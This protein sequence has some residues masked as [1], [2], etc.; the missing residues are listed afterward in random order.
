LPSELQANATRLNQTA[1]PEKSTAGGALASETLN[2]RTEMGRISRQSGIVLAGMMFTAVFGYIFKIYLARVLGAEALGIYAL[3]MT[4][5]GFLGLLNAMGLPQSAVR[6]VALYAASRKFNQLGLLL[7][8]GS[9]ILLLANLFFAAVLI[10]G[11]PWIA[12]HFYHAPELVR[13]LPLFA[14][15][16]ILGALTSFFGKVLAGYKEVGLRTIVTNFVSSPVTMAVTVVLIAFGGGLGGYLAAQVVSA[17]VVMVLLISLVWRLT[18]VA[19]RFLN[20]ENL[21]LEPE[22]WSFS[23]AMFGIGLMEFFMSQTDRIALGFY[24]GAHEVGIYAV[25]AALVAYES[26][27]LQSVNQIFS[28]VIADL[29]TRAEHAVLGRLFQT[30]TKWMLGLTFPLAV[31]IIVFARPIMRIFGHDFEIGW[32]ILVIGTCGQLVNCG[33]G[34]VGYLLLMSGNQR[35]LIRVQVAM[36]ALM[37]ALCLWLVPMWGVLGAATAAAITNIGTNLWNLFEVR[38]ALKLS[39]YNRS[40]VRLLPAI[41]GALVV[42]LLVRTGLAGRTDWIVIVVAGLAAYG[43]FAAVTFAVGLNADD[44]LVA[45]AIWARMQ[46]SFRKIKPG[47]RT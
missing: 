40:Y 2:F 41:A 30:L 44:L 10:E 20:V 28:P 22:V 4:I 36:A 8:K 16:M 15:I 42:T 12:T 26:I 1:P 6:F 35:R 7:W 43:T 11:G 38:S 39:P 24:R 17:V 13:Y 3:G 19:A 47:T 34:S 5:V 18:P 32:P 31:V 46:G 14:V 33:V 9:G 29:H 25:A 45:N 27:V 21:R 23:A 37:V